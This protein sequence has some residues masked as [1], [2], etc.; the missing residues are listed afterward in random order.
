M[1]FSANSWI[2]ATFVFASASL[3]FYLKRYLLFL[4]ETQFY[5]PKTHFSYSKLTSLTRNLLFLLKTHFPYSKLTFLNRNSLFLLE[6]LYLKKRNP[7]NKHGSQKWREILVLLYI[8]M[9]RSW[10]WQKSQKVR[11]HH[12]RA[13]KL[14]ALKTRGPEFDPGLLQSFGWHFKPR[15]RLRMTLA[16]G[17]T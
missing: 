10:R 15:S 8:Q 1:P 4:L 16:V 12:G 7:R 13:V 2:L 14:P 6:T 3:Y 9:L 17:G 11:S 5:L